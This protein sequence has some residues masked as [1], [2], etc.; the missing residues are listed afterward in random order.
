VHFFVISF[1]RAKIP[2]GSPTLSSQ[3]LAL[4][5]DV[6]FLTGRNK[7]TSFSLTPKTRI[8]NCSTQTNKSSYKF[9]L[10]R[11]SPPAKRPGTVQSDQLFIVCF[12]VSGV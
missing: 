8:G 2:V 1:S 11:L 9:T 4:H 6:S 7:L 3:S 12:E 10:S 5:F